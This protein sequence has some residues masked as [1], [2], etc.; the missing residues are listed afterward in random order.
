MNKKQDISRQIISKALKSGASLAGIANVEDLKKSPSHTIT[1]KMTDFCGVGTK[2][3]AGKKSGEVTWPDLAKSAVVIAVEHP[4]NAPEMDWWLRG[5]KGGTLGNAKL[6]DV[7]NKLSDWLENENQI[8]CFKIPYHIEQ[9]AVFMKDAAVLGGLGC[10]GKNNIL[11]T[12][13][14]GSKVR[15]RVMLLDI[16]LPSTG[17]Q[18]FDPCGDCKEYCRKSCPQGAFTKKIY[19]PLDYGQDNLPG[20]NGVYNR[21]A[22]NLQMEEDVDNGKDASIDGTDKMGKQVKHCRRC[23]QACPV[24]RR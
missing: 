11:V 3:V 18:D 22:C 2:P 17:I 10:I 8:K 19:S 4:L 5:L 20:R 13:R 7:F 12:P 14:F 24:G 15:L 9:G 16:D 6:I 1:G 23:E 21:Q